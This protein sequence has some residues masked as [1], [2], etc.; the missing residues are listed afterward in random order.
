MLYLYKGRWYDGSDIWWQDGNWYVDE[1][2]WQIRESRWDFVVDLFAIQ[3]IKKNLSYLAIHSNK[4]IEDVGL[5][6]WDRQ[7]ERYVFHSHQFSCIKNQASTSKFNVSRLTYADF[8]IVD[9][10]N[11]VDMQTISQEYSSSPVML[12]TY[13]LLV[14]IRSLTH[15]R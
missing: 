1:N 5:F 8:E 12:L 9:R 14:H 11:Y 10:E 7:K 15:S 3:K 4:P 2:K 6:E 13:C